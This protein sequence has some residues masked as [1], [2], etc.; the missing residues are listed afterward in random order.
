V[1]VR[2]DAFAIVRERQ[3]PATFLGYESLADWQD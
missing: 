3:E 1:R 2:G